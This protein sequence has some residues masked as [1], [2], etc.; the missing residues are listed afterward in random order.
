M[1]KDSSALHVLNYQK[2]GAEV[3]EALALVRVLELKML[4]HIE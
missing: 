4:E 2:C 3:N 1:L